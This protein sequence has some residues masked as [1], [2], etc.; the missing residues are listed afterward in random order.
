VKLSPIYAAMASIG[1]ALTGGQYVVA[2]EMNDC[3]NSYV[4]SYA[5]A[6]RGKYPPSGQAKQ[7]C[8]CA[9]SSLASGDTMSTAARICKQMIKNIYGLN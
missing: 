5:Q 2:S 7:Y 6:S 4:S 8:N 1:V 3:V 9:L